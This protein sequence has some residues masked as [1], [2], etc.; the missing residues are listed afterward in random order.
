MSK[1]VK[2]FVHMGNAGDVIASLPSLKQFYIKTNVK[3]IL[4]LYKNHP[5]EYYEKNIHPVKDENGQEVSLNKYMIDCLI[6]LIKAQ[7]Y[8]DDV[9]IYEKENIKKIDI[10]LSAIRDTFVNCPFGDI[11]RWYFYVFPDI[12]C[13]LATQ[14]IEVN[15][16]AK[17]YAKDKIIICRTARYTNINIKY[18]FLKGHENKI[19]FAGTISEHLNFCN[20]WGLTIPYL[21]IN[22]FLELAQALKQSKG[23]ISNQTMIFQIAEGLKI[24][25]VVELC[26]FAP[27]VIPIGEMAFDF[28]AQEGLESYFKLLLNNM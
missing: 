11:R 15:D 14:Y 20:E 19:L 3:P 26:S 16:A 10:N 21:V 28:Y 2:T 1:K 5:A 12:A 23:L 24:P 22:N 7:Y 13:N 4:Y 9:L 17:N 25:R 6:P 27:N 18:D 8:I